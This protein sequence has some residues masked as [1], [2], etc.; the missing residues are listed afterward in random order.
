[1]LHAYLTAAETMEIQCFPLFQNADRA[2]KI[3]LIFVKPTWLGSVHKTS[4]DTHY[5]LPSLI[6]IVDIL[7]D[8]VE[9]FKET[10]LGCVESHVVVQGSS[11]Q[12][13]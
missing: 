10:H 4:L 8:I 6:P 2:F 9:K 11:V 1:M 12:I 13:G 7:C 3:D 5:I